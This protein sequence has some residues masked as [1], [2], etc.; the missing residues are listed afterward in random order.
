MKLIFSKCAKSHFTVGVRMIQAL[1][2]QTV[3]GEVGGDGRAGEV[4]AGVGSRGQV[5]SGSGLWSDGQLQ[6]FLFQ[7]FDPTR[8]RVT[9]S[10]SHA[11]P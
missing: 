3:E 5:R 1:Y 11:P 6:Q 8:Q 7:L 9:A 10:S 4:Q 2:S